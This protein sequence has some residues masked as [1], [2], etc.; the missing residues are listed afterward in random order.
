MRLKFDFEFW[1]SYAKKNQL[2]ACNLWHPSPPEIN[3]KRIP[4]PAE[5]LMS[6]FAPSKLAI[7]RCYPSLDLD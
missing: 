1:S 3:P 4:D 5:P 7:A 6:K 2:I